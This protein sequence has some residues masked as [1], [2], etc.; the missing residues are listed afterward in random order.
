MQIGN[1]LVN[2]R[3]ESVVALA[4]STV[5]KVQVPVYNFTTT[6]SHNHRAP[7]FHSLGVV[8]QC[9]R[10]NCRYQSLFLLLLRRNTNREPICWSLG[11]T[12]RCNKKPCCHRNVSLLLHSHNGLPESLKGLGGTHCRCRGPYLLLRNH[13]DHEPS[14]L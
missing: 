7:S 9:D 12:C 8:R 3:Y 10:E 6:Q 13:A 2:N 5:I 4:N 1:C 14:C 11:G